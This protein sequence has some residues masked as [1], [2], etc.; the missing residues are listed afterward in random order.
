MCGQH[1]GVQVKPWYRSRTVWVNLAAL[2]LTW[3]IGRSAF[4]VNPQIVIVSL[5]VLN[6]GL[7]LLTR[8]GVTLRA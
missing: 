8:T 5:V 6:I 1:G 3:W 7:R 4:Y 2:L